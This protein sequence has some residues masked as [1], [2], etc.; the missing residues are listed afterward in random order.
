ML[1]TIDNL[2]LQF[3]KGKLNRRDLAKTLFLLAAVPSTA[4]AQSAMGMTSAVSVNHVHL[5]VSNHQRAADFYSKVL[6]ATIRAKNVNAEGSLWTMNIPGST[7]QRGIWLSLEETKAG[8]TAGTYDHVAYGVA[9]LDKVKLAAEINK[10]FPTAKAAPAGDDPENQR[11]GVYLYDPDGAKIQLV[12][13]V[14]LGELGPSAP[15]IRKS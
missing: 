9:P 7:A 1:G 15:K 14:E 10:Q 13:P 4:Q 6:G 5:H 2:L 11:G 12:P 3:E 8:E